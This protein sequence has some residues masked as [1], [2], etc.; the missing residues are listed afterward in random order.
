MRNEFNKEVDN[1]CKTVNCYVPSSDVVLPK[2]KALY[3]VSEPC[4]IYKEGKYFEDPISD[5][6][7]MSIRK[8]S[9]RSPSYQ[10]FTI[11]FT[12]SDDIV[13]K[14][15]PMHGLFFDKI[16]FRIIKKTII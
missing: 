1:Y 16:N 3:D 12:L 10:V 2:L 6:L 15:L 5:N 14:V 7:M 9:I 11:Q 8:V 13:T 4:G